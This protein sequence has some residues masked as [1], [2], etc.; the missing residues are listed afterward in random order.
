[1]R[2]TPSS[3]LCLSIAGAFLGATYIL[4]GA[5]AFI[6][7]GYAPAYF[8]AIALVLGGLSLLGRRRRTQGESLL[9][10]MACLTM[11][12]GVTIC[13]QLPTTPRKSMFLAFQKIRPG[14]ST[15]EAETLLLPYGKLDFDNHTRELTLRFRSNPGT[16]DV[17]HL[18]ETQDLDKIP[19]PHSH[20]IS[21]ASNNLLYVGGLQLVQPARLLDPEE[22]RGALHDQLLRYRRELSTN[23]VDIPRGGNG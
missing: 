11:I 16:V 18:N 21:K 15:I 4:D 5:G 22:N 8:A 1:M 10:L 12:V 2:S 17:I 19:A 20:Q 23:S 13:S 7:F 6:Y 9:F 3:I 14:M